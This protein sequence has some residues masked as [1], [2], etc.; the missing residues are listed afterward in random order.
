MT[1]FAKLWDNVGIRIAAQCGNSNCYSCAPNPHLSQFQF[2]NI[3][4]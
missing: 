4:T 1:N 2:T 3:C